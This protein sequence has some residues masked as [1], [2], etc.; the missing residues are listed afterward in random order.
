MNFFG[1]GGMELLVIG[2]VAFLVLGPQKMADAGK[3]VAKIMSELR[4]Q[5][6]ELTSAILEE[7][8]PKRPEATAMDKAKSP[9]PPDRPDV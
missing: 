5:K 1:I 9:E 6:D 2:L 4:K 7:P 3:T 8:R